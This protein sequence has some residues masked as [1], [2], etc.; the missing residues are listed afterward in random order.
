MRMR[1]LG[2]WSRR[3]SVHLAGRGEPA[4]PRGPQ[5]CEQAQL[6]ADLAVPDPDHLAGRYHLPWCLS[7]RGNRVGDGPGGPDHVQSRQRLRCHAGCLVPRG[8][9]EIEFGL[10]LVGGADVDRTDRDQR[11]RDQRQRAGRTQ[12]QGAGRGRAA[13]FGLGQLPQV[14]F[15]TCAVHVLSVL[16]VARSGFLA[17]KGRLGNPAVDAPEGTL[18]TR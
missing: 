11:L 17:R 16:P 10:D 9:G 6:A 12:A 3:R 14:G 13:Q 1:R 15:R 5:V 8:Q 18:F 4:A 2:V 7:G